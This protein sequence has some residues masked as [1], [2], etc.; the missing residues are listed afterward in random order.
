MIPGISAPLSALF[1]FGEK[2]ANNARNVANCNTDGFKK[3]DAAITEGKNGLPEVTLC[4]SDSSGTLVEEAGAMRETSNVDLFEE[5][6]QMMITQRGYAANIKV[7]E[8]QDGVFEST[9]DILA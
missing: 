4:R 5:F 3:S 2:L 1:A 8:A 6:P 7:L 9:L